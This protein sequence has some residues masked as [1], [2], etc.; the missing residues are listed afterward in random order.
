MAAILLHSP[1]VDEQFEFTSRL[2]FLYNVVADVQGTIRFLDTK[3]AF[4][5]TLLTA[6]MAGAFQFATNHHRFPNV[7]A[8]FLGIFAVLALLCLSVCV[9]VIFPTVHIQGTF[10]GA[11]SNEPPFFLVPK[12]RSHNLRDLLGNYAPAGLEIT[13][14]AYLQTM[15]AAGDA[16][17][18]RSMCDEVVTISFLRQVKSDRLHLAIQILSMTT[19]AFFF[20]LVT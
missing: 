15:L 1:A 9:R 17:L 11:D 14:A 8:A 16:E 6:M 7:H 4:C 10:S 5:V 2:L 20:Q 12:R 13:H 3:A 18:V 19:V